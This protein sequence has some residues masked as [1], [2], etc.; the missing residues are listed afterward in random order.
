MKILLLQDQVYLPSLGGGNKANRLLLEA[1]AAR[2]HECAAVVRAF[3]TRAGPRDAGELAS[4]VGRRGATLARGGPGQFCFRYRDVSVTAV[5]F[6]EPGRLSGYVAEAVQAFRPDRILVSDDKEHRLVECAV[7]LAPARVLLLLQTVCHLP[8]GPHARQQN[9]RQRSLMAKAHRRAVISVYLQEYLRAHGELE[10][11]VVRL[12][13]FGPGPFHRRASGSGGFVTMIN[14]CIE[15]GLSIFLA[16]AEAFPGVDFAAVPTWGADGA[17]LGALADVPNITIVP[18]AD[19]I[20]EILKDTRV[21]L[22]PSLWP[23]SFGYVVVEAMLRGIPVVASDRGGLPEAK[24]GV[25]YI[26]PV[27]PAEWRDGV[28]VSPEQDLRP[29]V[30]ALTALLT[31]EEVYRRC[32]TA[33]HEAAVTFASRAGVDA[34]EACLEGDSW[35]S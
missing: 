27:R 3:T 25:D 33:S 12:P 28:Y 18:S 35:P 8:F 30:N 14:P 7:T 31:D 22:A 24:L 5:D 23:E 4:E 26:V 9:A 34:F 29:W 2:G 16:L 13:V 1:L 15:K 6:G 19:D 32:A 20:D 11:T 21:L 17:V 10:S